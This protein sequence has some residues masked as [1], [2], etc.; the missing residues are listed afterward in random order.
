MII[1]RNEESIYGSDYLDSEDFE[2]LLAAALE[3]QQRET[4]HD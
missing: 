4:S 1:M 2:R 3:K